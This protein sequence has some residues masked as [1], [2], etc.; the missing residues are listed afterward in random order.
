MRFVRAI[1]EIPFYMLAPPHC[2]SQTRGS[3]LGLWWHLGDTPYACEC[4]CEC[5]FFDVEVAEAMVVILT[6]S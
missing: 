2:V 5:A 1:V 4:E 3:L 6:W